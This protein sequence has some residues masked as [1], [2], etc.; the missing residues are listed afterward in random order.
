MRRCGGAV[1]GRRPG[2]PLFAAPIAH[3]YRHPDKLLDVA[4]IGCLLGVAQGNRYALGSRTRRTADP[5]DIRLWHVRHI[6]IYH[7]ADALDIDSAGRD[8]R[9]DQRSGLT[10]AEGP[11]R[12]LA[13]ALRLVAVN[14]LRRDTGPYQASHNFVGAVLGSRE[15]QS[16][17]D[18]FGPQDVD[19]H[20]K[21]SR[22]IDPDNALFDA[23]RG[24]RRRRYCHPD[25]LAQHLRG[26]FSNGTGHR[27]GKHQRLPPCGELGHNGA[28]VVDK[29]H[30]EHAI[31]LVEH[32]AFHAVEAERIAANEVE[33]TARRGDQ[34]L[35]AAKQC[36]N[37]AA[38]RH[39]PNREGRF[40][41][42]MTAES[43]EALKDLARQLAGRTEHEDAAA[44][45]RYLA[46]RLGEAVQDRQCECG[47]FARPG[48]GNTDYVT[49]RHNGRN[50]LRLDR[51]RRQIILFGER[52]CDRLM[53]LEI[54]EV[55]QSWNFLLRA[56]AATTRCVMACAAGKQRHPARSGL[57]V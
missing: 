9:G 21:L 31:G 18:R 11:E 35:H 30:V 25:G 8:I 20:S 54:L 47:G 12:A 6:V 33:Q 39:A 50:R 57:P 27:C 40:D 45:L 32:E 46:R 41:A 4:Q 48:L 55:S 24:R 17:L 43:A 16:A 26:K 29:A 1:R 5:M 10:L 49:A 37:L 15:D 19:E 56:F 13:L 14:G 42:Q 28:D 23:L 44:F 38:H 22:S 34:D 51:R 7:V 52:T 2:L 36:A 53:K 3:R